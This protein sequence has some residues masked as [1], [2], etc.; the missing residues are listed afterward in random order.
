MPGG[1]FYCERRVAVVGDKAMKRDYSTDLCTGFP[2]SDDAL[3]EA[4]II[5]RGD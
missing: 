2:A 1:S 4:I 5:L 3:R